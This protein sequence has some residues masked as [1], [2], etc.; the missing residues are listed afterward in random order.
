MQKAC[1]L[2]MPDWVTD[3][4]YDDLETAVD[5]G[6]DYFFG[7]GFNIWAFGLL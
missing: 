3:E 2:T 6:G 7:E 1:N 5:A 4:F